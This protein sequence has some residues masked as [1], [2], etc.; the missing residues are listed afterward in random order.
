MGLKRRCI[1]IK[2][3]YRE[4]ILDEDFFMDY[5]GVVSTVKKITIKN[6]DEEKFYLYTSFY[7]LRTDQHDPIIIIKKDE[8]TFLY[9]FDILNGLLITKVWINILKHFGEEGNPDEVIDWFWKT[10]KDEINHLG[11]N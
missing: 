4:D 10:Y 9:I 1:N 3:I 5:L 7:N 11:S 2:A 6:D 8:N